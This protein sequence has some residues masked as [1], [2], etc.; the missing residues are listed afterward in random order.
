[1]TVQSN[2]KLAVLSL[3]LLVFVFI[4][5]V[6]ALSPDEKAVE[7]LNT[8]LL[9]PEVNNQ[10]KSEPGLLS[11]I[12]FL[13]TFL[14]FQVE[15]PDLLHPRAKIQHQSTLPEIVKPKAGNV[16]EQIA[17]QIPKFLGQKDAVG[18]YQPTLPKEVQKG[19]DQTKDFEDLYEQANFPPGIN[20]IHGL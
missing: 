12:G 4:P 7:N 9:P 15:K 2:I 6:H 18:I 1:M 11:F 17:Q 10:L 13:F 5:N 16:L 3:L 20:P 19:A 8:G 14:G